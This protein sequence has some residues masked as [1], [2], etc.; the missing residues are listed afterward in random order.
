MTRSSAPFT[1]FLVN[2]TP[3][4]SGSI[5]R[6]TTTPMRGDSSSPSERR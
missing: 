4:Q 2:M 5:I 3:A 6:C 1:G